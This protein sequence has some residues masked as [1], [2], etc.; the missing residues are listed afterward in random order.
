MKLSTRLTILFLFMAIIPTVTVGYVGYN[1]GKRAIIKE[2][3][4]HLV[5]VNILKSRELDRWIEGSRNSI[6]ELAQRPAVKEHVAIMVA[7]HD[8]SDHSYIIAHGYI[9][10]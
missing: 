8:A 9:L 5:S 10:R 3:T 1:I 4:G 7:S 6:E 2:A